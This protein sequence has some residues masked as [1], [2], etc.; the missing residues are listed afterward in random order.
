MKLYELLQFSV[1]VFS[2]LAAGFW[3]H[4]CPEKTKERPKSRPAAAY[5]QG[6]NEN[7]RF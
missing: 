4:N 5:A 6:R 3:R 1:C 7:V 2:I